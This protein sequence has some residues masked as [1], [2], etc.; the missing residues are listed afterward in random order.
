MFIRSVNLGIETYHPLSAL[1]RDPS[2]RF[3]V[4]DGSYT[5][6]PETFNL[7]TSSVFLGLDPHTPHDFYK[8][9]IVFH[10]GQI[11]SLR[12]DTGDALAGICRVLGFSHKKVKWLKLRKGLKAVSKAKVALTTSSIA[13]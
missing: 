2:I 12:T 1:S 11:I 7:G 9:L 10:S 8:L 3:Q 4:S 13:Y 5:L 6:D